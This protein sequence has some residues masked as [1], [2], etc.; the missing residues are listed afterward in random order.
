MKIR[1]KED[2]KVFD[3]FGTS[4]DKEVMAARYETTYTTHFLIWEDGQWW[5]VLGR[6]FEPYRDTIPGGIDTNVW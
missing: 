1:R 6:E 2:N 4:L 3:V 5:W